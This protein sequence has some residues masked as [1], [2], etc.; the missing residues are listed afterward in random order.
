MAAKKI[1]GIAS[2]MFASACLFAETRKVTVRITGIKSKAPIYVAAFG[3]S[4]EMKDGAVP[5]NGA[6][7]E[8]PEGKTSETVF[9]LEEDEYMFFV[10]Q[11]TNN[12][13]KL[14]T[15]F[16]GYPKEPF[17]ISNYSGG[18]PS[19]FSKFKVDVRADMTVEIHL[20]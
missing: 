8:H 16:I 15:N 6:V 7:I 13:Q 2:I 18:I 9:D 12:D 14:S 3:S 11:D 10:F 1:F 5:N 19:D 4:E 17:G 20:Q